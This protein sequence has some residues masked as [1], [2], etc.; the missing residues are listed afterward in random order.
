MRRFSFPLLLLLLALLTY[1][2]FFWER[3]FYWDEAPWTWI[4]FGLGQRR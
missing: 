2:P 1:A 3:G 4:Y